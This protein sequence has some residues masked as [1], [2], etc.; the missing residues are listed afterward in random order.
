MTQYLVKYVPSNEERAGGPERY[1]RTYSQRAFS[2][3]P[4]TLHG[5]R[6]RRDHH[7]SIQHTFFYRA[8]LCV[9]AVFAVTRCLYVRHVVHYIQKA[10]DIVKLLSRHGSPI[11]LVF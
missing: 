9:S 8:T 7:F 6:G 2:D 1:F 5:D 10:E 11:V 4:Q 3:L